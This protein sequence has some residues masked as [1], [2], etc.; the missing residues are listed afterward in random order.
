MWPTILDTLGA[1]A[2]L[3]SV[4]AQIAFIRKTRQSASREARPES[5]RRKPFR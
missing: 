3:A 5:A 1:L 4:A 2:V